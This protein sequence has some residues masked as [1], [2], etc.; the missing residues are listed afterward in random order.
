[1]RQWRLGLGVS[2]RALG[3]CLYR[4]E[5]SLQHTNSRT[6]SISILKLELMIF[7]RF[8]DGGRIEL[9]LLRSY[10]KMMESRLTMPSRWLH[11]SAQLRAGQH[12]SA[13]QERAVPRSGSGVELVPLL[14]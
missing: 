5:L 7:F 10:T 3:R 11:G 2:N 12:A 9:G 8:L 6:K 14:G 1:M 4:V 13:R